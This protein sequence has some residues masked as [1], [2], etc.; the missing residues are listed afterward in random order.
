MFIHDAMLEAVECGITEVQAR[1]LQDQYRQLSEIDVVTKVTGLSMQ[2]DKLD[3]TIHHKLRRNTGNMHV[4]K[5]KNRFG[6][7][8]D[9]IPC[10][11]VT[12]HQKNSFEC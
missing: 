10:M 11:S 4:N 8:P 1:E 9:A 12:T 3:I 5:P 6:A 2:F 7:N